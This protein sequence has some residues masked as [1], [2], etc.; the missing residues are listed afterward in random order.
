MAIE[1]NKGESNPW[2]LEEK[3]RR[4]A[5]IT[6]VIFAVMSPV[7][8]GV[9]HIRAATSQ[10]VSGSTLPKSATSIVAKTADLLESITPER[11]Q[12]LARN[13]GRIAVSL[14]PYAEQMRPLWTACCAQQNTFNEP[15]HSD[16]KLDDNQH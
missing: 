15:I 10:F 9:Q 8:A 2:R 4:W 5:I 12:E 16:I 13:F 6:L 1:D 14:Q 7:W 3:I 11:R